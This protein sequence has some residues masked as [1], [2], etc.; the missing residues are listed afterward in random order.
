MKKHNLMKKAFAVSLAIILMAGWL[1]STAGMTFD[2]DYVDQNGI[3]RTVSAELLTGTTTVLEGGWYLVFANTT[4][5][6]TIT[7]TGNVSLILKDGFTLTVTGNNNCPGINVVGDSSLS[8]YGQTNG[9]GELKATGGLNGAG[10]GVYE[11]ITEIGGIGGVG[12]VVPAVE[13]GTVNIYGGMVTATGGENGAGIGGDYSYDCGKVNIY[14]GTVTA[15]GNLYGAGIGGGGSGNGGTVSIC[16]GTVTAVA[17]VASTGLVESEGIGRGGDKRASG[18]LQGSCEVTG[19]SVNASSM[20]PSPTNGSTPVYLT[21]VKAAGINGAF[22]VASLTTS[23]GYYGTKD[24]YTDTLGYMNLYLPVGTTVTKAL[25]NSLPFG[26]L[27]TTLASSQTTGMMYLSCELEYID[28]NGDTKS[29]A[30]SEVTLIIESTATL[31]SGWYVVLSDVVSM[32]TITVSGSASL[33]LMDGC[34]LT[35]NG[36]DS[37]AGIGVSGGNSLSIYGQIN[38]TGG[39]KTMG[40]LGAGIGGGSSNNVGGAGGCVNI[41]GGTIIAGSNSGAGIGG[42]WG[43]CLGSGGG[44]AGG[45]V[46]I[47]GGTVTAISSGGAAIGG[48]SGGSLAANGFGGSGGSV[49]IY[50]GTVTATSTNGAGIGGGCAFGSTEDYAGG[51][52]GSVNI[53]GGT[54]TATSNMGAGIGGGSSATNLGGSGGSV[55]IGGGT[56]TAT[57]IK[58]AGIGGGFSDKLGARLGGSGTCMITGGSTKV[59]IMSPIPN[60]GSAPVYLTAVTLQG[61]NT[62]TAAAALT[63]DA[64]YSYGICDM[65]TDAAGKLYLWLPAGTHTTAAKIPQ[66]AAASM[67]KTYA[68][69]IGTSSVGGSGELSLVTGADEFPFCITSTNTWANGN[70][71]LSA[72]I[73]N[74]FALKES[75][76]AVIA[77]YSDSG[78]LLGMRLLNDAYLGGEEKE[79]GLSF[80]CESVADKT[81][82]VFVFNNISS[83]TPL[84]FPFDSSKL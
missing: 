80:A 7:V 35:V 18:T 39:L 23:A 55:S 45:S 81:Y 14:G 72:V 53:Y 82:K 19:G 1:P 16:G 84:A 10:I 34:T 58:G 78:K 9:M 51:A 38:G 46:N 75:A 20:G 76:C 69:D 65:K 33:L 26:G 54:V 70:W 27:V 4:V 37:N 17:G 29:I 62:I 63:T 31:S 44:G 25:L 21:K 79:I 28:E 49:N 56:V 15:T 5:S 73:Q 36:N 50:G 60:N 12:G 22:K 64:G 32:S 42:G 8:I 41:Y 48:S 59:S 67:I 52:G 74:K 24:I 47:Y 83:I 30:P 3:T 57:S 77:V 71:N 68:G 2:V 66:N 11:R 43:D 13:I 61:V 40:K 6:S